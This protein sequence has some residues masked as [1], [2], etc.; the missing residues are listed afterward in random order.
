MHA[1][2]FHLAFAFLRFNSLNVGALTYADQFLEI[3]TLLSETSRLFGIG[4][5]RT[6]L[7]IK[8]EWKRYT[9]FNHD[10]GPMEDVS[11]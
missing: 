6:N 9:L 5:H 1:P 10:S 8:P 7:S 3:S 2:M 11:F 4:E